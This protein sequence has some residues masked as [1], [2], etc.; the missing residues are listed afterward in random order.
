MLRIRFKSDEDRVNGVYCLALN[1]RARS[2]PEG[3]FE[4]PKHM[5]DHLDREGIRY[6]IVTEAWA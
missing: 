2:L 3:L 4:I 6:A 1:G 5:L